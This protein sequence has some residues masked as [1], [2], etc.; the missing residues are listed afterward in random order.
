M[1]NRC[2][3]NFQRALVQYY[4]FPRLANR[5]PSLARAIWPY[6]DRADWF[7]ARFAGVWVASG[8]LSA[9]GKVER[10]RWR[11]SVRENAAAGFPDGGEW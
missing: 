8:P 1:T 7:W 6:L 3:G 10:E 11:G 4:T 9:R 2:G 5:N